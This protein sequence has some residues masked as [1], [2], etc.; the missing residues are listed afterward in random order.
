MK[1]TQQDLSFEDLP[2]AVNQ[3]LSEVRQMKLGLSES[4][5]NEK[6]EDEYL[7]YEETMEKLKVSR[8]TLWKYGK[9]GKITPKG[10]GKRRFY[11]KSDVKAFMENIT[12]KQ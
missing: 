6:E 9:Q 1:T 3:I 4:R 5:T 8:A 7:T 12:K 11:S 2:K 10:K